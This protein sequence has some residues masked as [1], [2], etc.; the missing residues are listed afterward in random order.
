M[1]TVQ[2]LMLSICF[3][4]VMGTFI[5]NTGFLIKCAIDHYKDKKRKRKEKEVS[6]DQAE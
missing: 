5:A 3:G 2:S 1:T 6:A 4:A